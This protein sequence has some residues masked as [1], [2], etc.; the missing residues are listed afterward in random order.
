MHWLAVCVVEV[1]LTAFLCSLVLSEAVTH[2]SS[3]PVGEGSVR[4]STVKA[5]S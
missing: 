1:I 3:K 2:F 5:N 4:I